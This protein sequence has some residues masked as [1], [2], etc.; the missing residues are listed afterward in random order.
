MALNDCLQEQLKN[1]TEVTMADADFAV[2]IVVRRMQFGSAEVA[3]R[4]AAGTV[5]RKGPLDTGSQPNPLRFAFSRAGGVKGGQC[6]WVV[7]IA[8]QNLQDPFVDVTVRIV[9]GGTVKFE[10]DYVC[11][12]DE[13]PDEGIEIHD[14]VKL[15]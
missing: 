8:K 5:Q 4:D 14:F 2:E 1:G 15:V 6:G 3:F 13:L 12:D 9:Q 7:K 10:D 11:P